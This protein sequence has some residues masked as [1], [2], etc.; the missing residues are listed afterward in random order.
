M[1]IFNLILVWKTVIKENLKKIRV[2]TETWME[3]NSYCPYCGKDLCHYPNNKPVADFYCDSCQEDFELKSKEN[4]FGKK[5]VDGAY[6]TMLDRLMSDNNPNLFIMTYQN[7][8]VKDLI[9]IPKYFFIPAFIEKRK[10]LSSKARRTGWVGCNILLSQI[11]ES[12]KIFYI[13]NKR[14]I[15]SEEVLNS[16]KK[17]TFLKDKNNDKRGWLLDVMKCIDKLSKKEFL[18]DEIYKFERE[19]KGK[20]PNNNFIKDK[21][22]QQLQ[23]LR[24]D[25]FIRF[26]GRGVYEVV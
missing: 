23:S 18:L 19:L 2:L 3:R 7:Y 12:G 13:R 14:I 24:D 15:N 11:P 10:P 21:I 1:K 5:I 20:H 6:N 4:S 8:E 26:K 16:L 22:R 17:I 25:G 9:L